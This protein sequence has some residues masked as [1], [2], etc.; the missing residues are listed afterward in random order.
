MLSLP[1]VLGLIIVAPAKNLSSVFDQLD[2]LVDVRHEIVSE[3]VEQ[4][5]ARKMTEAAV[6]AMVDSLEDP[7]T[8]FFD[9]SEL[10]RFD[11]GVRGTF[12]GIG[13]EVDLFQDRLRIVSP[14]EDSPAYKAGIL[15]G[16]VVLEI[17]GVSTLG[18]KL[19]ECIQKLTGEEGTEVKLKVRHETGEEVELTITRARIVA[20]SVRGLW[21]NEQLHWDFMIDRANKIGYIRLTQ[22]QANT[23][24]AFK[25]ALDELASQQCKA[26]ILDLR[27][28][29]GGL[30]DAAVAVS[31]LFL[32]QGQTIVSV[33]GRAVPERVTQATTGSVDL[34]VVVL[35]NESSASASEVVTGAL[36]DNG[37]CLFVGAR[38]FGK[39][40]VQQV[41]MLEGGAGALKITNAHYY[42]PK[43]RNIHHRPGNDVWG[44]D[45]SEGC[46]VP[47]KADEVRAMIEKTREFRANRKD[48]ETPTVTADWILSELADPQFAAALR[49]VMGKLESG[50]W[51]KVG[52]DNA[53]A[54][55]METRRQ[56]LLG[57]KQ[58]LEKRIAKI[59]EELAGK[60]P[61]DETEDE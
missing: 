53:Q 25:A 18:L 37:R 55:A 31:D 16:D 52:Q 61:A 58:M 48:G 15:P 5:D 47:M 42:L 36:T 2:L 43:G 13:A 29:P 28:N 12:S 21:R 54:L 14:M 51:P 34:P 49:A 17:D 57:Q 10:E 24:E 6:R 38:T 33:K 7:Y 44:V 22:F 45:P 9:P 56:Q 19:N 50:D 4:P 46:Y 23:G 3:Y 32:E 39:G 41:R 11:R 26:L 35:A 30:L 40:S 1:L 59:D 27:F 8:V 60:K 20:D